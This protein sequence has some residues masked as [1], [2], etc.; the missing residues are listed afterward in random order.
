[1]N[2]HTTTEQAV[3]SSKVN[4]HNQCNPIPQIKVKNARKFDQTT[5]VIKTYVNCAKQSRVK[6]LEINGG[7]HTWPGGKQYLPKGIVG[8]LSR[9]INA[10][11]TIVDFFLN[12]N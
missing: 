10:S 2:K 11:E 9:E 4:K 6:L 3:L 1:M 8:R 5:V 12:V 7:G